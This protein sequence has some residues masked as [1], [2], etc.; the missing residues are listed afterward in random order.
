MTT[1][2]LDEAE[3]RLAPAADRARGTRR[4]IIDSMREEIGRAHY[5]AAKV[6][7]P[8]MERAITKI[9]RPYV[10]RVARIAEQANVP[11]PAGMRGL[12]QELVRLCESW[13]QQLRQGIDGWDRLAPP[14]WKDGRSLDLMQRGDLVSGIRAALMTGGRWQ[15]NLENLTQQIDRY[16]R[17]SGWPAVPPASSTQGG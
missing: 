10:E 16:I 9:Y 17:E 2:T 6:T 1:N 4:E 13:P 15:E 7:L 11:V 8:E 5:E 3:A 14:I 12:L